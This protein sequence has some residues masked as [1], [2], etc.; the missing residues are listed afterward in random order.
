MT[1]FLKHIDDYLDGRLSQFQKQQ[2][3]DELSLNPDLQDALRLEKQM[4]TL[5]SDDAW[6]DP[7]FSLLESSKA[8]EMNAF[9]ESE[10][11]HTIRDSIQ[12]IITVKNESNLVSSK[13][14]KFAIAASIAAIF[15]ISL[16]NTSTNI[17]NLYPE[18]M[19]LQELPS[20]V[21]RG[22]H[23]TDVLLESELLFQQGRYE[24]VITKITDYQ[25]TSNSINPI[26]YIYAGISYLEIGDY[27]NAMTQF[28][29]LE[30]SNSLHQK[31]HLWYKAMIF[32]K[33]CD[34][35]QLIKTLQAILQDTTNYK[36][37]EALKLYTVIE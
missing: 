37:Q 22:D 32:L 2:F 5:L 4:R 3:E 14:F 12:Q 26:S 16:Y 27:T 29:L 19:E 11:A 30:Q 18:Y 23:N 6:I 13:I 9:L 15:L 31:K 35:K 34:K 20:L 33:Q 25:N 28:N 21:M 17:N 7:N 1:D 10:E 24:K 36:Y 8:L